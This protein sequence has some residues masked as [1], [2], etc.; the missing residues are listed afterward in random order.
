MR[1]RVESVLV[2]LVLATGAACVLAA[3]TIF[4]ASETGSAWLV[5]GGIGLVVVALLNLLR[6]AVGGRVVTLLSFAANLLGSAAAGAVAI[7][8][9]EPEAFLP[10]VAVVVV[11]AI[12]LP[13]PSQLFGDPRR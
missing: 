7:S 9:G 12:S 11:T 13:E 4:G 2:W 6:R 5:G 10:F 8:A 3:S 1:A